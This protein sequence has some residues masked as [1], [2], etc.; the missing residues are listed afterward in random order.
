MIVILAALLLLSSCSDIKKADD[1]LNTSEAEVSSIES[2]EETPAETAEATS[3]LTAEPETFDI[4]TVAE[5]SLNGL[6]QS[7]DIPEGT[8][9]LIV[10]VVDGNYDKMYLM[11]KQENGMWQVAYGPFDVQLGENGLGKEAEGD[12]KSPE[13]LYELGYAFGN[14]DAPVG[15]IWPWRTTEDGDLWIEDSNSKYYNMFVQEESIEDADWKNYSNLN[16]AAFARA[17]EIRYNSDRVSGA[18]SAIF[19]HIWISPKRDTN[20]CTAISRENI[21]TLIK[22]LDPEKN[23]M[24][25]QFN[26][27]LIGDG[28]LVYVSDYSTQIKADIKFADDDNFFGVQLDGY[29][30]NQIITKVDVAQALVRASDMLENYGARLVV[31]DAYRPVEAFEQ[32]QDWLNDIE[33][34]ANQEEYYKDIDK[35]ALEEEYFSYNAERLYTRAQVVH[36]GLVDIYGEPLDIGGEYMVFD[37]FTSYSCDNLTP[38]QIYNR[39]LLHDIMLQAGFTSIENQWWKFEYNPYLYDVKFEEIIE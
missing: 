5:R 34:N 2:I 12:G 22:W 13:G 1:T 23:T 10:V 31:Y 6:L 8:T 24:I 27:S 14:G 29:Y 15:T 20:G 38:E 4:D 32:I 36:V 37:E 3:A 19:L 21:E 16:I 17:V 11:E 9:Q 25:A 39:E 18:G 7:K 30:D 28:G 26:H 35:Q 33:D